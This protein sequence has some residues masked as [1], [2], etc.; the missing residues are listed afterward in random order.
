MASIAAALNDLINNREISV[1]EAIARHFSDDYRQR[2]DGVWSDRASF[3]EHIAHLR[4]IVDHAELRVL[5]EIERDHAYSDRHEARITKTDGAAVVQE[6]YLFGA[7]A[8]DGRFSEVHEVT[9]MISGTE[10]DRGIGRARY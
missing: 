5:D 2:T 4:H 9:H 7:L 6:V 1:E 3:A 8:A 10:A